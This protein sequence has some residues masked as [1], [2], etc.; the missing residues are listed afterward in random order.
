MHPDLDLTII[1]KSGS[2][3]FAMAMSVKDTETGQAIL[4]REPKAAEQV[5]YDV[6][7]HLHLLYVLQHDMKCTLIIYVIVIARG[8]GFMAVNQPSVTTRAITIIYPT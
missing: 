5:P 4:K 6:Q 7:V 8:Q 2:T 1:D 3:P